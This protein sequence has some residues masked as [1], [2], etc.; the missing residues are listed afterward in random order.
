M[1]S[2]LFGPQA[3]ETIAL[4]TRLKAGTFIIGNHDVEVL[5]PEVFA[6]WPEEWVALNNWIIEHLNADAYD[7]IRSLKPAGEYEEGGINMALHHGTIPGGLRHALPDTPDEQLLQLADGS[8]CPYVLF[9]HSHV[10]FSREIN[11]QTFINPGSV[12]QPR[13]GKLLACYGVF[14]DGIYGYAK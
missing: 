13:C 5:E 14:E 10:Q 8:D 12:G 4:L 6:N 11:G 2:V 7:L 9:G 3:N 1:P